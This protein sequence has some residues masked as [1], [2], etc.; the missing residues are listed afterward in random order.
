[1]LPSNA[2]NI[3]NVRKKTLTSEQAVEIFAQ[4]NVESGFIS[5][6][7]NFLSKKY[8]VSAKTVR[9]IWNR[10]S[11][12]E[13]TRPLWTAKGK[14]LEAS[15]VLQQ[16]V[17]ENGKGAGR[18][19]SDSQ[20]EEWNILSTTSAAVERSQSRERSVLFIENR[21]NT[22]VLCKPARVADTQRMV[23]EELLSKKRGA[24]EATSDT[25]QVEK[26][27][28]AMEHFSKGPAVKM[29][30]SCGVASE[31][32]ALL[33]LLVQQQ[34]KIMDQQQQIWYIFEGHERRTLKM[35]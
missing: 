22:D 23:T 13:V 12:T 9:D 6:E 16:L 25:Q 34:K 33:Q 31:I 29:T 32:S 18:C 35:R 28:K 1:M 5:V 27:Q 2:Q 30:N 4:R 11:W 19:E 21:A 17:N 3:E 15:K 10:K 20:S 8:G 7:S 24:A 26:R 14:E